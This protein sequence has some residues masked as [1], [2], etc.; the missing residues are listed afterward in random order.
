MIKQAK[1]VFD[2]RSYWIIW[3]WQSIPRSAPPLDAVGN[4]AGGPYASPEEAEKAIPPDWT[5]LP[6]QR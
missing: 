6:F 2:G 1:I 4:F 3:N 5:M